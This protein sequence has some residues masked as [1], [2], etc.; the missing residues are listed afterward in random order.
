[1]RIVKAISIVAGLALVACQAPLPNNRQFWSQND[2]KLQLAKPVDIAVMPPTDA[3][4]RTA[5]LPG[6]SPASLPLQEIRKLAY[7][8]LLQRRYSPL[9]LDFVDKAVLGKATPVEASYSEIRE[10]CAADAILNL[11]VNRWD[12]S[13]LQSSGLFSIGMEAYLVDART[14]ET[15]WQGRADWDMHLGNEADQDR[16]STEELRERGIK[17]FFTEF[18]AQLPKRE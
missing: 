11:T 8:E 2:G 10:R 1:M 6:L 17:R 16:V 15:I 7:K 4:N 5:G 12:S 3:T 18:L 9:S 14:G 13:R